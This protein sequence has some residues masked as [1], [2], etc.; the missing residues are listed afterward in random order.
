MAAQKLVN[1]FKNTRTN[2]R[3]AALIKMHT[4]AV[5]LQ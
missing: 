2:I 1:I 4:S 3:L 5:C